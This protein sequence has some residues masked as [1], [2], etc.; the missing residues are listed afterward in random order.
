MIIYVLRF[1]HNSAMTPQDTEI[2]KSIFQTHVNENRLTKDPHRVKQ[3]V[4][5]RL[6]SE[7]CMKLFTNDIIND[8]RSWDVVIFNAMSIAL[9]T[10]LAAR[11]GD[12]A[13]SANYSINT[14]TTYEDVDIYIIPTENEESVIL[15]ATIDTLRFTK[16]RQ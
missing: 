11:T 8:T 2:T 13:Q 9:H 1:R 3:W 6:V 12:I 5:S 7:I 4:S 15:E 10:S 14:F 16:G